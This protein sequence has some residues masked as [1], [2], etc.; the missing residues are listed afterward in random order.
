ME[1][2]KV[3][4]TN[5]QAP[6]PRAWGF[7]AKS[8]AELRDRLNRAGDGATLA[9]LPYERGGLLYLHLRVMPTGDALMAGEGAD[10]N[11][12]F[13]CP[14]FTGCPGGGG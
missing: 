10:I 6:V 8:V 12:S 2:A 5:L 11:E 7:P 14:P 9:V 1:T 13:P 3:D 4:T